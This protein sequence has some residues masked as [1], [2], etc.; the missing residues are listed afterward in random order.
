MSESSNSTHTSSNI[1]SGKDSRLNLP[2][3][4][5][6]KLSDVIRKVYPVRINGLDYVEKKK[7]DA[8]EEKKS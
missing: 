8:A 3:S 4:Q 2:P 7:G 6:R 5:R 1:L